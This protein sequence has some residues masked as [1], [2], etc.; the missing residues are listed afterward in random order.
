MVAVYLLLG[1]KQGFSRDPALCSERTLAKGK[2]ILALAPGD[3]TSLRVRL[4]LMAS[5]GSG[6][7]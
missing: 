6:R 5:T 1:F 4:P 3:I 2:N 7:G